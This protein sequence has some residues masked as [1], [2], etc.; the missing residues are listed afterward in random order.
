MTLSDMVTVA[1][2]Y[3]DENFKST[4]CLSFVNEAIGTVN[5]EFD[6]SLPF[7]TDTEA[8]YTALSETWIRQI[9]I[10]YI[11][12]SIKMND[13]SVSEASVF[14]NSYD[15]G[16]ER[17]KNNKFTAIPDAYQSSNFA[18]V[19]QIDYVTGLSQNTDIPVRPYSIAEYDEYTWYYEGDYVTYSNITYKCIKDTLGN[20]PTDTTYWREVE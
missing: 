4:L 6:C 10:P 20:L 5:A 9:L 15:R 8:D 18:R 1:N 12:Y 2:N 14:Q 7:I 19:F 13:G 17:L 11:C 3:T 16:M